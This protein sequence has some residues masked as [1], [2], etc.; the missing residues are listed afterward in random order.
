[1]RGCAAHHGAG[2]TRTRRRPGARRRDGPGGDALP[3]VLD[4]LGYGRPA[5]DKVTV[6]RACIPVSCCGSC[7]PRHAAGASGGGDERPH[8]AKT[9]PGWRFSAT[10]VYLLRDMDVQHAFGMAGWERA[11]GSRRAADIRPAADRRRRRLTRSDCGR[12]DAESSATS[13]IC[14]YRYP[15]NFG[16]ASATTRT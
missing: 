8:P 5:E 11:N 16:L 6:H 13:N 15:E 2:R 14:R 3:A 4:A 10:M 12:R 1:M 9:N 7:T